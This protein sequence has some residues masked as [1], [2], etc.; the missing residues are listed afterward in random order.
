MVRFIIFLY[1]ILFCQ[2]NFSQFSHEIIAHRGAKSLA[3]EN[4][5]PAF[6]IAIDMKVDFI[7][8][9]VRKSLDDSLMVMH[10]STRLFAN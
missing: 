9:D 4:T 2:T 5:I 10:D 7:E 3:P 1:L 8:L 6:S